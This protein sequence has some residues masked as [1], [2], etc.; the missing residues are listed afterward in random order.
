MGLSRVTSFSTLQTP[1]LVAVCL[2]FAFSVW[3]CYGLTSFPGFNL[4]EPSVVD[5]ALTTLD[6]GRL[7]IPSAG[8]GSE[9]DRAYEYQT[10]LHALVLA[11][12]FKLTTPSL[13]SGR[14]LS[15]LLAVLALVQIYL[16]MAKFGPLA[17][18]TA[19]AFLC[20]DPVFSQHAR[21]IRYDWIAVDGA[22]FAFYVLFCAN[23][24]SDST[25]VCVRAVL[26]G[27]ATGV[28]IDAHAL[29]VVFL[30]VMGGLM[31]VP[32]L[33]PGQRMSYRFKTALCFGVACLAVLSPVIFYI[34]AHQEALRG[35]LLYTI[36][37]HRAPLYS[38]TWL[39]A[40]GHKYF[41]Y[42]KRAPLL[43]ISIFVFG[44]LTARWIAITFRT[45]DPASTETT[46][47]AR[48][49][50]AGVLLP[51][52]LGC[53]SGHYPWHHLMVAPIWAM[54]AG[55]VWYVLPASGARSSTKFAMRILLGFAVVSAGVT[56]L[57]RSILAFQG[58]E[59][60]QIGPVAAQ[61][62]TVIPPGSL[63]YGDYR[64]IFLA[65]QEKWRFV[66]LYVDLDQDSAAL[67]RTPFEY[68]VLSDITGTPG[69]LDM[70]RYVRVA[71]VSAPSPRFALPKAYTRFVGG[72]SLPYNAPVR[73]DIYKLCF[74]MCGS[75]TAGN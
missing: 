27:A 36:L 62:T 16:A 31:L 1:Q 71:E 56:T 6:Q 22:L 44:G 30:P 21:L 9:H 19:V 66:A 69:W 10:P 50:F 65:H 64:M 12:W 75:N 48:L 63:V 33:A 73:L 24:E 46:V 45:K 70:S 3:G 42:Y 15:L 32:P 11:V 57:D 59:S 55:T 13:W 72:V 37:Q 20:F 35:Q 41:D 74:P 54:L 47:A 52:I 40:E 39:V 61:I 34:A 26:A 43:L 68:L 49:V 29:Y 18:L 4:D 5:A 51:A 8:P 14:F 67:G 58:G 28:A 2:I 7:A 25:R 17:Q 60:R 38:G 53:V 23:Q